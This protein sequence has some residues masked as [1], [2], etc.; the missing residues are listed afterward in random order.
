MCCR[1]QKLDGVFTSLA[2]LQLTSPLY[3]STASRC[4]R[5]HKH[6]EAA[7]SQAEQHTVASAGMK[8]GALSSPIPAPGTDAVSCLLLQVTM[9]PF[10]G[11]PKVRLKFLAGG[12]GGP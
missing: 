4:T 2:L 10:P 11:S 7:L 8:R 5:K 9:S 12:L 3:V 1:E 6:I